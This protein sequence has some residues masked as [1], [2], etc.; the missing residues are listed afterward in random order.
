[1]IFI[2]SIIAHNSIH[3]LIKLQ[4]CIITITYVIRVMMRNFKTMMTLFSYRLQ[5]KVFVKHSKQC[6]HENIS[7]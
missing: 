2:H 7:M 6:F 4:I 3:K 5:T 1:M